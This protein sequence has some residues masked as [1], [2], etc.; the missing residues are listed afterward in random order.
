MADQPA[1]YT[2]VVTCVCGLLARF[3]NYADGTSFEIEASPHPGGTWA[4]VEGRPVFAFRLE[5]VKNAPPKLAGRLPEF[6]KAPLYRSHYSA[7]AAA[8]AGK[9]Q[10]MARKASAS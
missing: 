7:H 8:M 3:F 2:G 4:I 10:G 9:V 5:A 6:E 1:R